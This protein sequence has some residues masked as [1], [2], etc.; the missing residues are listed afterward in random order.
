MRPYV[1]ALM[2][3]LFGTLGLSPSAEATQ[4]RTNAF[5]GIWVGGVYDNDQTH[6]FSHCGA[7]APYVSGIALHVA[8]TRDY[9]WTLGFSREQWDLRVNDDIPVTMTFDGS[10]PIT[11]TAH[12]VLPKFVVVGMAPT[13]ELVGKFRGAYVMTVAAGGQVY[14]FNLNSTSRLMLELAHCVGTELAR[15]RGEPTPNYAAA[16]PAKPLARAPVQPMNS[17]SP[18]NFSPELELAATRIASNLLLQT[19]LPNARLLSPAEAPADLK[20]RGVAWTSDAGLGS[21]ELLSAA[22]GKDPQQV[23]SSLISS[24]AAYCK[25]DFASGRSSELV[26]DKVVTK[27]FTGC[28]DSNG[29]RAYRYFILQGDPAGY[30]VY[31][32][33][34][35]QSAAAPAAAESSPLQAATFQAAAVKAAYSP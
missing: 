33:S 35:A 8:V 7:Y 29:A 32:L 14:S 10:T 31:V 26:D 12:V 24:D 15:E 20:G 3:A 19:K 23:A 9:A 5:S 25:G 34:G 2:V 1:V 13:S 18:P 6:K 30:I 28:K 4:T 27:A 21:V 22:A 11:A 16:A 17:V